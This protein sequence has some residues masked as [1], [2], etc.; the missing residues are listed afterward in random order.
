ME[1]D[2]F[3]LR[4]A[5]SLNSRRFLV[6]AREEPKIEGKTAY[7]LLS[8]QALAKQAAALFDAGALPSLTASQLIRQLGRS[9]SLD[10]ATGAAARALVA[11]YGRRL[12]YFLASMNPANRL[13]PDDDPWE[14]AYLTHWANAVNEIILGGGLASGGMGEYIAHDAQQTLAQS[15]RKLKISVAAQPSALPL[16]GAARS[17]AAESKGV[18]VVADFGQSGAKSGLANYDER[19]VL[20]S[21]MQRPTIEIA[22]LTTGEQVGDLAAAMC[23][24]LTDAYQEAMQYSDAA[25]HILCALAAYLD[26]EREPVNL[27]RGAYTRLHQIAQPASVSAW[28]M[29]EISKGVGTDVQL[30]FLRDAEAAALAY[31]GLRPPATTAV[32]MLGSALGVG[33]VP[34]AQSFRPL[35]DD[36]M[37]EQAGS[38]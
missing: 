37:L 8:A 2:L 38:V 18:V 14:T 20:L 19:G 33:F 31:A 24:I 27:A 6:A 30:S 22:A 4:P 12:G 7:E 11:Q 23:A 29:R 21:I 15:G 34:N 28:L 3:H 1:I 26:D 25:P 13:S 35:A 9:L 36:F 16:I 5:A 10:N 17:Y 32:L